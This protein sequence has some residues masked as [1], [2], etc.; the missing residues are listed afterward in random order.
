[1]GFTLGNRDF[2]LAGLGA[3][4][5]TAASQGDKRALLLGIITLICLI[6]MLDQLVWRPLLAWAERFSVAQVEN[7][8][9]ATS[10]FLDGLRR[11]HLADIVTHRLLAP[12]MRRL[13][14]RFNRPAPTVQSLEPA[15]QAAQRSWLNWGLAAVV[16]LCVV[17]GVVRVLELLLTLPLPSFR[18]IAVGAAAT[19]LRVALAVSRALAWTVPV[20][21]LIGTNVRAASILQPVV[22]ILASVPATALFP[23]LL[24]GLVNVPGGANLAAILLML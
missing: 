8:N 19:T 20:G 16:A 17:Y 22:Q 1:E 10:W 14:R 3:Y 13:E 21:V 18:L 11:S 15:G 6:V 5:Q 24:L 9:P 7:D 2:R 12:V 4:L 23:V